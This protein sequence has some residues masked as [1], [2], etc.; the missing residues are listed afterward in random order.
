MPC[1]LYEKTKSN[2]K[3]IIGLFEQKTQA[4]TYRKMLLDQNLYWPPEKL[5]AIEL[6][7]MDENP[8]I[9]KFIL[10]PKS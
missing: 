4:E 2:H 3:D 8:E 6:P 5:I 1:L 7:F 9:T 10:E